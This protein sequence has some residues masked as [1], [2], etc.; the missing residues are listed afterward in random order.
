MVYR[1]LL[2]LDPDPDPSRLPSRLIF[3]SVRTLAPDT[4]IRALES[5]SL[6]FSQSVTIQSFEPLLFNR[7]SCTSTSTGDS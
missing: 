6:L 2:F 3:V 7:Q 4:S 5:R 1:G